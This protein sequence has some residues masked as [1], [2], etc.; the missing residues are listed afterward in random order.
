ML[1][2]WGR[3]NVDKK[4]GSAADFCAI[5]R[6]IQVVDIFSINSTAHLY[7]GAI[8]KKELIGHKAICRA[9]H[10]AFLTDASK[11]TKVKR[12]GRR[13][14]VGAAIVETFPDAKRYYQERLNVE[15]ALHC[16]P[17]GLGSELRRD[18]L[19]EPFEILAPNV[20]KQLSQTQLD[21]RSIIFLTLTLVVPVLLFK[22]LE[23][24]SANSEVVLYSVL[25]VFGALSIATLYQIYSYRN[26]YLRSRI[27]PKLARC[28]RVL[29][30]SQQE[31]E[32]V[33]SKL[34]SLDY[35]IAKGLD[36]R[37]LMAQLQGSQA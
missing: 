2:I 16:R 20:E 30:P 32:Q 10:T 9:C 19:L 12:L 8:G 15:G 34:S 18:L 14:S 7:G 11:Y 36:P 33:V 25:S 37:A 26:R 1:L 35:K 23:G 17:S 3:K 27:Y 21:L 31:L 22:I 24:L 6:E 5:C 13:V 4:L 28:L 29:G